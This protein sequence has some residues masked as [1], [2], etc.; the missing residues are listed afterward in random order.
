MP[1][2]NKTHCEECY[3]SETCRIVNFYRCNEYVPCHGT[4]FM[5]DREVSIES[6]P[7]SVR[8]RIISMA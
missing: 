4:N 8:E 5:V 1:Y 2:D 7:L 3:Y 6:M